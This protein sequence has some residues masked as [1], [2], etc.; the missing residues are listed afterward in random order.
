MI[1][2]YHKPGC[3]TSQK[4]VNM[5]KESGKRFRVVHYLENPLSAE[6]L[7]KLIAMLGISPEGL[8]RTKE[9]I[10]SEKFQGKKMTPEQII[11]AIAQ[12][13]ILMQRPVLVKRTRA[14]LAR[15]PESAKSWI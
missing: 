10:W 2:V 13:P 6:E 3:I 11:K 15:P 12:N 7:T 9:K 5:L 1:T 4:V 8:L 14:L